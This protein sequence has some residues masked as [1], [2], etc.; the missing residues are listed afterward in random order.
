[1]TKSVLLSFPRSGRNWL[2]YCIN[3][4]GG[5]DNPKDEAIL[6]N[7]I[8]WEHN[9]NKKRIDRYDK[10][11]L[12]VRNY[13]ECIPRHYHPFIQIT[14]VITTYLKSNPVMAGK[15][16]NE[17]IENL[18]TYNEF[19]KEKIIVY[20]ED[21]I[22]D[23]KGTIDKVF[24][25]LELKDTNRLEM[26]YNDIESHKQRSIELHENECFS[27]GK[28]LLYHSK[29]FTT[30]E[31]KEFDTFMKGSNKDIFNSRLIRYCS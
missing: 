1:M 4:L 27:E 12:L 25:F 5:E 6:N 30:E 3:Y 21:L 13:K 16:L 22:T 11:I 24:K 19:S 20:Y 17:Y 14:P 15:R 2:M 8:D 31:L 9:N 28:D 18:Q 23:T 26:F 29:Q 7:I 10:L